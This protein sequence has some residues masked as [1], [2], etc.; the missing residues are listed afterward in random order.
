MSFLNQ[1]TFPIIFF[2]S[3]CCYLPMVA[4]AESIDLHLKNGQYDQ[5]VLK[6]EGSDH[7]LSTLIQKAQN[8]NLHKNT[9]WLALM[10]YKKRML[11]GLESEVDSADFFLSDSGKFEPKAELFATLAAFFSLQPVKPS[12]YNPQCRFPARYKWLKKQLKFDDTKLPVQVCE[13]LKTYYTAMAPES[14]TVVFPSTHPNSPSSMFGHTLLR[15]NKKG[16][17]DKTR[18]LAFSI[19]YAAQ[20][21]PEEGMFSYTVL[22]LSGGFPGKFMLLPYYVKLREYG[23][24]ENRDLWEYDLNLNQEQL[25][26]ILLH[27]FELAYSYFDY[28][29]FTENCSYHLLSLLNIIYPDDPLTDEFSGWTIPVD[30]LKVL[31]ERNLIQDARFYPSIARKIDERQL[32]MSSEEKDLILQ[33]NDKGLTNVKSNLASFDDNKQIEILDFLTD[34]LR[35]RKIKDSEKKVSSKLSKGEREVLLYR[36]KIKKKS[37]TMTIPAPSINP[38]KGHNTS[39]LGLNFGLTDDIEHYEIEW[40]PAYHDILDSSAGFVS[41]SSLEFMKIKARYTPDEDSINLQ[42]LTLLNVESLEPRNSFFRNY[43]WHAHAKWINH[44]TITPTNK[45]SMLDLKAGRGVTYRLATKYDS[46]FYGFINGT[47]LASKGINKNYS[48]LPDAQLSYIVEPLKGWRID[49]KAV[50]QKSVLGNNLEIL[51]LSLNQS[52]AL[53]QNTN[54]RLNLQRQWINSKAMNSMSTQFLYYF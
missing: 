14:L 37:S 31:R 7:Y 9:T 2:F 49:S 32:K 28:Y 27:T 33:A 48:I 47:L 35:Y 23:Q 24:I 20:I 15:V 34:Y 36:S 46:L 4:L 19:N 8:K 11:L 50:F 52:V 40:R 5:A 25:E 16:Q 45:H 13:D 10:H 29:F 1:K 17:T 12:K 39:R 38:D 41:S 6:S 44:S 26:F 22:G 54:I 42:E 43:S 18:M 3:V 53:S 51:T 21:D 30:T